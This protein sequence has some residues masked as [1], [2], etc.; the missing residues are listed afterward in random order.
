MLQLRLTPTAPSVMT[1][2]LGGRIVAD[3]VDF[4]EQEGRKIIDSGA[5]LVADLDGVRYIDRHG[6]ALLRGW[7]TRGVG[8]SG[9][10][11]FVRALLNSNTGEIDHAD[12]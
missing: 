7:A 3:E 4:L 9:G 6:T 8:L 12:P 11:I 5:R 10:S 2:T 1:L